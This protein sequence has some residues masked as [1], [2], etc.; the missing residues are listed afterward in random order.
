MARQV[1]NRESLAEK[2]QLARGIIGFLLGITV[3]PGVGVYFLL[4]MPGRYRVIGGGLLA[5]GALLFL[6]PLFLYLS[7]APP[8]WATP[9]GIVRLLP[10]FLCLVIPVPVIAYLKLTMTKYDPVMPWLIVVPTWLLGFTLLWYWVK[11]FMSWE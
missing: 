8:K 9:G 4:T 7:A 5:F 1:P 10:V 3:V 6:L 2:I 11:D